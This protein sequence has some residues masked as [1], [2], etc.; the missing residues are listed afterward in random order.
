MYYIIYE[1]GVVKK[2]KNFFELQDTII[3]GP[4][5]IYTVAKQVKVLRDGDTILL[6][7]TSQPY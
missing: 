2:C 7:D 1:T 5:A 3:N 6:E 4:E